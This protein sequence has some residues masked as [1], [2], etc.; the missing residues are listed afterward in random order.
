MNEQVR[1]PMR[2]LTGGT[3]AIDVLLVL[4]IGL[5]VN[6]AS[7][8][9]GPLAGTE[10]HRALVAHQMVQSGDWLLPRLYDQMYLAKPPLHYW[11]LAAMEKLT[12]RASEL[13]WRLPSAV[14]GAAIAGFLCFMGGVW[15]G[16]LAGLV[17][18]VA[19][20]SLVALWGQ[21]HTAEIDATNS[22]AGVVTA[23]LLI[24]LGFVTPRRRIACALAAGLAFG[25]ELLLKGPA[26]LA[27]IVGALAGPA[28]L[29]RTLATLKQPW[30][31]IALAIGTGMFGVYGL[32]ALWKFHQLQLAP[33]TSGVNEIWINLWNDDR[34]RN[35]PQ[36]LLIPVLLL[37]YAMPVSFFL[38]MALHGPLW[39]GDGEARGRSGSWSVRDRQV[40]RA[41]LGSMLI[42][43]G[44][45]MVCGMWFPRYSYMWLP[46]ICPVA[47]AA[48]AAWERGLYRA[49]LIDLMNIALVCVGIAFTVGIIVMAALCWR[50]HVG[51]WALLWTCGMIAA[52]MTGL[53][54]RWIGQNRM[55]WV[56]WGVIVVILAASG[57]YGLAQM[58]D[59]QRRSGER[60]AEVVAA[61]VARG[62]TVTTGHLILDQPEIFYYA[63]LNVRS[64]PDSLYLPR[65]FPTSRW[66]LLDNYE[67]DA[68]SRAMP[69]RLT[70]VRRI[71]Y[72]HFSAA[73][74][75]YTA[76]DDA[77]RPPPLS[78]SR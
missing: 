24:H 7:L 68:W 22:L 36:T 13:V 69:Q 28:I 40:L 43:C 31:W 61:N 21:N 74:A 55:A 54:V 29:N 73:L 37:V 39:R 53:I 44:V 77:S 50:G 6:C 30:P 34:I 27:A 67:Y 5:I 18:G 10:G 26:G 52:G 58:A 66:M 47:G 63:G 60:C 12:G 46:L 65:E 51:H 11:I 49:K 15:F 9:E 59:R 17:S 71:E 25:A 4:A 20:C 3:R 75:W 48:A 64:Y 56:G 42:A 32:A 23:C 57:P 1:G 14:A 72:R 45:T 41:L 70:H 19:C 38:P 33:E 62:E 2:P 76:R 78:M 16:R 8:G 35:L